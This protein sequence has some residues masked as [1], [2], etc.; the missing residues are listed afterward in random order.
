MSG[1]N[2]Q[3]TFANGPAMDRG[4]IFIGSREEVAD[5]CDGPN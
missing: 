1:V 3:K 4:K 5:I 2:L